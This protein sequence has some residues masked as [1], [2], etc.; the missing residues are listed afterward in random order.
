MTP[1]VFRP[2]H[3][4]PEPGC[5]GHLV[6][7]VGDDICCEQCRWMPE[8]GITLIQAPAFPAWQSA[9]FAAEW[10]RQRRRP[11]RFH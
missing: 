1:D 7:F 10:D 4:C 3:Q 6:R 2:G 8:E 5:P 9:Q 11:D